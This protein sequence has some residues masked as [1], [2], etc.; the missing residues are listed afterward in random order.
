MA[1][2]KRARQTAE[3]IG[4]VASIDSALRDCDYG[5]WSG[6]SLADLG[7][8]ESDAL[9]TWMTDPQAAPHGGESLAG[10][11]RRVADWLEL[12]ANDRMRLLAIS[13]PAVIRAAI[14]HVLGAPAASFWHIDVPPL[15]LV[16]MCYD[17]RRWTLVA[18]SKA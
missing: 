10:T 1:P 7:E 9:A 16:R 5:Q 4:L 2:E 11:I 8:P 13:H 14:V 18:G 6:R 17:G 3:A 12:H 15:G